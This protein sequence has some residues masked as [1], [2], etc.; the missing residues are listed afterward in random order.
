[1]VDFRSP[2]NY[3]TYSNEQ[4]EWCHIVLTKDN[5]HGFITLFFDVISSSTIIWFIKYIPTTFTYVFILL[6][7]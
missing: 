7:N 5:K 2:E 3:S 1:M 6:K 4:I